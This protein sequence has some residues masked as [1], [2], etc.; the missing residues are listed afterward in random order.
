M[1]IVM[2]G[3]SKFIEIRYNGLPKEAQFEYKSI[4]LIII[5]VL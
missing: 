5:K 4:F 1:I 2:N 3:N